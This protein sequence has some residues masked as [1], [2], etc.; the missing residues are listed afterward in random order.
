MKYTDIIIQD[1]QMISHMSMDKSHLSKYKGIFQAE[2]TPI[3]GKIIFVESEVFKNKK[4]GE[5]SK[6]SKT[7]TLY[8]LENSPKNEV[9]N[10]IKELIKFYCKDLVTE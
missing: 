9:F 2:D 10:S 6:N 1:Y 3:N 7:E 5:F 8:Y 4:T